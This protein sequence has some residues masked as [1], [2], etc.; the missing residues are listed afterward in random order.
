MAQLTIQRRMRPAVSNLI[1]CVLC[2][3]TPAQSDRLPSR[4]LYPRLEDHEKVKNYPSIRGMAK[5]VWFF[6]HAHKESGGGDDGVS[7]CN[8]FEASI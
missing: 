2:R 1:R 5:D 6:H 4:C 8:P 3:Y 7:K